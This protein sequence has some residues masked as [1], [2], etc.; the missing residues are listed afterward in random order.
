MTACQNKDMGEYACSDRS[1]CWEPC[2]ELGHS[3]EHASTAPKA[4]QEAIDQLLAH[5]VDLSESK[6]LIVQ[7]RER[8][9]VL[10]EANEKSI[11]LVDGLGVVIQQQIKRIA[12]LEDIALAHEVLK[13]DCAALME[14]NLSLVKERDLARPTEWEDLAK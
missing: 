2:G 1:Q 11:E 6:R 12:F 8:I 3:A 5:P 7:L 13:N 9:K 14:E 4:L 10:N